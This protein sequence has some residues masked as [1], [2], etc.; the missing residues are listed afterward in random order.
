MLVTVLDT[1][2]M[3]IKLAMFIDYEEV[4]ASAMSTQFIILGIGV[5]LSVILLIFGLL[6]SRSIV[7]PVGMMVNAAEAIAQ[8]DYD[9]VPD[10]S[11]FAGEVL[12]LHLAMAKMVGSLV[13]ALQTSKTK[14]EE[15][16]EKSRQAEIAMNEAEQARLEAENAKRDGMLQAAGQLEGIATQVGSASEELAAQIDQ[17][18][19]G[20]SIQQERTSEAATAMEEMNASVLEVAQNASSAAKMPTRPGIRPLK[21]GGLWSRSSVPSTAY[22]KNPSA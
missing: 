14:S 19:Q 1:P 17:S 6:V 9:N 22:R 7:R 10:E 4:M 5:I 20:T 2:D 8:G 15:A 18:N 16:E 3:G 12:R 21:A 13:E 11:N